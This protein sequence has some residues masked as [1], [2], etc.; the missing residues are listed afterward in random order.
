[1]QNIHLS[2][3]CFIKI[4]KPKKKYLHTFIISGALGFFIYMILFNKLTALVSCYS[5]KIN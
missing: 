3:I 4:N 2:I 1:M 5:K